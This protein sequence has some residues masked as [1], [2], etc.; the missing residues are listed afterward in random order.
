MNT[1][2]LLPKNSLKRSLEQFLYLL[3]SCRFL[4]YVPRL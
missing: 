2:A 1:L 3:L 4:C